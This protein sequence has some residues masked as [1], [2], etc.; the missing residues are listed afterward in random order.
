ML[1]AAVR[2]L[3]M[4]AYSPALLFPDSW[5]YIATGLTG[6]FVGLPTVHPVGYPILIRLLTLPDRSLAEL[7]AFQHLAALGV[8]IA[9]YVVLIRSRLPR[10]AAAAAAA[11]VLLDGY[12]ITLEQYV[13]SDTFFTA[14]MV[15]AL[16]LLA[17][18][19]LGSQRPSPPCGCWR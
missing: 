2:V 10:W 6:S 3:A 12:G 16:L 15:L 5:G 18:P 1:G 19:R 17:G 7:V 8:G 13:M 11:L 9:V 4:I 14:G